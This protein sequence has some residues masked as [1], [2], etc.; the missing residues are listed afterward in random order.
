[1]A[2]TTS[3]ENLNIRLIWLQWTKLD[4][5]VLYELLRLRQQVL[6]V[7]QSSPYEDLDGQDSAAMHLL[8]RQGN[9]LVGYL[10]ALIPAPLSA[11]PREQTI[12]S[13][14]RLVVSNSHRRQGLARQMVR[15]CL[16]MVASN[17][18]D[19]SIEIEAQS[20]LQAFYETLGFRAIGEPYDDCGVEHIR[21]IKT[22]S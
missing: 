4:R 12:A 1:M 5:D 6:I 17:R 7:E 14:G 18:P 8:A 15:E 11:K 3:H 16:K 21:M 13:F 10:R 20:Y 22:A 19:A 2:V 9:Q